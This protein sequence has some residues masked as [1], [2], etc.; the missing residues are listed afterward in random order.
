ML[1]FD[2]EERPVRVV[3]RIW[4]LYEEWLD[5]LTADDPA[6]LLVDSKP[7]ARFLLSYRRP[8]AVTV[9]IVHGPHLSGSSTSTLRSTR[10]R[11]FRNLHA[12]D[13]VVLVSGRQRLD[14]ERLLGPKRNLTV[15]PNS[16]KIPDSD[17]TERS[18]NRG[19]G[20]VLSA[21]T[22]RKRVDHALNALLLARE[23]GADV[24]LD[25]YC[26]GPARDE[27]A[28]AIGEAGRF[29]ALHGHRPDARRML[30]LASF[31]LLTSS[32]EGSPWC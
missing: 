16:R 9:H 15:I 14:A 4:T 19:D 23:P 22:Q 17:L 11:V 20:V 30:R 32:S 28:A 2:R 3:R 6:F 25:V 27:I 12:L 13:R 7:M 8:N 26:D 18:R 1:L 31:L 29:L 5:E 24:R 21:L 10:E